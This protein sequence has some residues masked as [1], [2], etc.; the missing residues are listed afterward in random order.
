MFKIVPR[1]EIDTLA[2]HPSSSWAEGLSGERYL[3]VPENLINRDA[4]KV[5]HPMDPD[6]VDFR[7]VTLIP[8]ANDTISFNLPYEG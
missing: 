1:R 2:N 4:E 8:E 7:Q 3:R 5:A 6:R